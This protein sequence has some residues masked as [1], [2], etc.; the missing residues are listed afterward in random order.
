[1]R[2]KSISANSSKKRE[3]NMT[4]HRKRGLNKF[5]LGTAGIVI[6]FMMWDVL[7]K[8][9]S[10]DY[11]PSSIEII[12]ALYR[13]LGQETFL[14]N[15]K[16]SMSITVSGVLYAVVFGLGLGIIIGEFDFIKRLLSPLTTSLRGIASLSLFPILIV[17]FGISDTARIFVIFWTAWPPVMLSTIRGLYDV[18]KELIEVAQVFGANRLTILFKIKIPLSIFSIMNGIKIGLGTGWISLIAAEMLGASRGIGFMILWNAQTFKFSNAFAYVIVAT[19][20]LGVITF[21]TNAL[22][23]KIEK[24]YFN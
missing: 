13:V 3:T 8:V 15:L 22:I 4:C 9:D 20:T 12:K 23:S 10:N 21:F 5:L 24:K 17:I 16:V 1:V 18:D 6:F 14:T 7:V 2:V 11:M 19:S